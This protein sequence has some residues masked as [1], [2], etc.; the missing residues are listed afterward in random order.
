MP[1][2]RSGRASNGNWHLVEITL[3]ATLNERPTADAGGPYLAAV[4]EQINFASGPGTDDP[5]GD[6]LTEMW[7]ADD[8]TVAGNV[9]TAGSVPGIYDVE[10]TVNDRTVDSEPAT[11]MVVVYDLTGGFVTGGGWIDS[12]AGAY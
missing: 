1:E 8:G 6:T 7:T 12:P 2:G 5:D 11:T 3:D 10:L 4:G 9:Y